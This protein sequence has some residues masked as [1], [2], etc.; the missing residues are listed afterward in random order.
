MSSQISPFATSYAGLP[1]MAAGQLAASIAHEVD[2]PLAAIALHAQAA[3]RGIERAQAPVQAQVRNALRAVLEASAHASDI[4]R[5]MRSLAGQAPA[6]QMECRVDLAVDE[7]VAMFDERIEQLGVAV[8]VAIA[9]PA[10]R[11]QAS[12]VQLRQLL[13]NLVANALDAMETVAPGRRELHVAAQLD[14][15]GML[16]ITVH[17]TGGG[18]DAA[19]ARRAFDPMFTTKSHG[20]GMG[21]AICRAIV[22]AHGGR[23][24]AEALPG[25]GCMVGFALPHRAGQRPA[26]I[27]YHNAMEAQIG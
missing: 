22:D 15:K 9:R 6:A 23:I 24:W 7:I 25:E 13:R 8:R 2:Q 26:R 16:V 14:G 27:K 10:A 1:P 17:D 19:Q 20:M 5:S 11:V 4:V 21:L 12:P 18:M 3:L